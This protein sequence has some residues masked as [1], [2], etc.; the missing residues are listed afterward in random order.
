ML[1]PQDIALVRLSFARA[2]PFKDAVADLFYDRLFQV[3]PDVRALFPADLREQKRKLMT[4]IATAVG[5]LN[6]LQGLVP[7]IKDL[8]ARHVTY[9]ATTAHYEVVGDVL[10]WT[11]E[12][13][14]R[15]DFTP[16][17]RAAWAKVYGVLS[18]TMQAGAAEALELQAA[19]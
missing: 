5:A 13:A 10:L 9:G 19:E 2:L 11:L 8:G 12:H 3:A 6:D 14:L 1:A 16:D 4:M 7:A 17:I 18:A 15:A